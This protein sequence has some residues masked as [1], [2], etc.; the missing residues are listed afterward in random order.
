M[1][2]TLKQLFLNNKKYIN[3]TTKKNINENSLPVKNKTLVKFLNVVIDI[4]DKPMECH[5]LRYQKV[6]REYMSKTENPGEKTI[7]SLMKD[8]RNHKSPG[9]IT[10][11]IDEFSVEMRP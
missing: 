7:I 11:K 9:L 3:M 2:D 1:K 4:E 5:L 6:L 8:L 10:L